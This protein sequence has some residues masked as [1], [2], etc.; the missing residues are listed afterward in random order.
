MGWEYKPRGK[1][2]TLDSWKLFSPRVVP[3]TWDGLDRQATVQALVVF[4]LSAL[5]VSTSQTYHFLSLGVLVSGAQ[6]HHVR[7]PSP[8]L[9]GLYRKV[10]RLRR[11][12]TQRNPPPQALLPV[13]PPLPCEEAVLRPSTPANTEWVRYYPAEQKNWPTGPC[14]TSPNCNLGRCDA[15]VI[16]P[17]H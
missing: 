12:D 9:Q 14:P 13:C 15:M 8:Q 11:R 10:L 17:N 5:G 16:T 3:W 4:W 2:K 7:C 1:K 6:S